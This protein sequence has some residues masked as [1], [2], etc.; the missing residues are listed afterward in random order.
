MNHIDEA[1]NAHEE[2]CFKKAI[3]LSKGKKN[4][5]EEILRYLDGEIL[6]RDKNDRPD[7]ICKCQKGKHGNKTVYVGIEHFLVDQVSVKQSKKIVSK[8]QEDRRHVQ[9]IFN[10][11]HEVLSSGG[12]VSKETE[13]EL[14]DKTFD[15]AKNV[16]ESTYES[17][18][19]AFQYH[20]HKHCLSA[21]S[22]RKNVAELSDGVPIEIA[23]LI[24]IR[25]NFPRLFFNSDRGVVENKNGFMPMSQD[26][27]NLLS[28][29]PTNTVDYVVLLLE[30]TMKKD[31][32]DVVAIRT[33]NIE[34]HLQRQGILTYKYFGDRLDPQIKKG[35]HTV[36]DTGTHRVH[37]DFNYRDANALDC[38][39][40]GIMGAHKAKKKGAP[41]VTTR[42][43]E[44]SLYALG[45]SLEFSKD[46]FGKWKMSTLYDQDTVLQRFDA[47]IAKYPIERSKNE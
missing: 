44:A 15:L 20:L 42:N 18:L 47:F 30:N 6:N 8:Y 45:D 38:C 41:F 11:A 5:T 17:F 36:D 1:K 19:T 46:C 43:I 10:N 37:Y 29:I 27:V 23:F 9:N 4:K 26:I 33:G 39:I 34:K 16:T 31:V 2:E 28:E 13:D 14:V 12:E 35:I 40:E 25:T 3:L 22:Y 32:A 24:E 21:E 7:I